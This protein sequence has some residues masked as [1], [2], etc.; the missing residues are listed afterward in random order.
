MTGASLECHQSRRC[1]GRSHFDGAKVGL[2]RV[3]E[4]LQGKQ[5]DA[6]AEERLRIVLAPPDRG[7]EAQQGLC[8]ATPAPRA[9]CVSLTPDTGSTKRR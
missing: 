5:R 9:G 8:M 7:L 6:H 4:A 2:L 1:S 3:Q